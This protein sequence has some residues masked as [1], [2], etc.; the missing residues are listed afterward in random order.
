MNDFSLFIVISSVLF[1]VLYVSVAGIITVIFCF[2]AGTSRII[3]NVPLI[4]VFPVP[5]SFPFSST[6]LKEIFATG[7]V[8]DLSVTLTSIVAFCIVV[9]LIF[10]SKLISL[11]LTV[12]GRLQLLEL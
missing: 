1:L 3:F 4:S 8:V 12:V 2:P 5:T 6:T 11:K 7:W 10:T 9:F